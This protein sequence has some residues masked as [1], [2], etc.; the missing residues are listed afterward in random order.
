MGYKIPNTKSTNYNFLRNHLPKTS[1]SQLFIIVKMI[2]RLNTLTQGE[3]DRQT[4]RD[5]SI[6]NFS[7]FYYGHIYSLWDTLTL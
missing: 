4:K 1:P 7:K 5:D 2:I 3:T 6:A